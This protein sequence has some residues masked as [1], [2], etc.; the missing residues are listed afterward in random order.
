MSI[1]LDWID[2]RD[3]GLLKIS[4]AKDRA[5]DDGTLFLDDPHGW[6]R[7]NAKFDGCVNLEHY[8]NT[9]YFDASKIEERMIDRLHICDVNHFIAMMKQVRSVS[10]EHFGEQ[11]W[12]RTDAD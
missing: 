3:W 12:G 6:W 2:A 10:R 1:N 5:S 9:P 7:V 4:T 8:F 11:Y